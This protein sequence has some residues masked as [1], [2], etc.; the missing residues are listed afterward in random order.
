MR[1]VT[2]KKKT[3]CSGVCQALTRDL[4]RERGRGRGRG[5]EREWWSWQNNVATGEDRTG[6]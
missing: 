2:G 6:L 5:R 3:R 1:A 4:E